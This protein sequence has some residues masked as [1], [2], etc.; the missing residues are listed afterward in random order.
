MLSETLKAVKLLEKNNLSF[1][2]INLS[3][4]KP[5]NHF[6]ID[7]IAKKYKIFF[8]IEEHN[9]FGGLGSAVAEF[10]CSLPYNN[11]LKIIGVED[12]FGESGN[13]DALFEKYKIDYKSLAKKILEVYKKN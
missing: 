11:I 7:N 5:L 10:I 12:T 3:T 6:F 8:T 9:I 2:I 1:T 4:I 13:V